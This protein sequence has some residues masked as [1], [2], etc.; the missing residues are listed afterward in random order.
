MVKTRKLK[1]LFITGATHKKH[2]RNLNHFQRVYFLSRWSD[3]SILASK[4]SDFSLSAYPGTKI[5]R[6]LFTNKMASLIY[7]IFWLLARGRRSHF[8][9][10]ITEPS[11][12]SICGFWAKIILNI[13]WVVDVWDIP[14]RNQ[15]HIV[16]MRL[17]TRTERWIL[18]IL[19]RQ[20]DLFI[21]SILPEYEL[22]DFKLPPDKMLLLKNA[23]WLDEFPKKEYPPSSDGLFK[24]LC[25]RGRYSIDS[26]LDI[27]AQAYRGICKDLYVSL[28]I[29]GKIST[30]ARSHLDLLNGCPRVYY[31]DFIEHNQLLEMI[32]D[33][34]ACIIPYKNVPDLAQIYPV[35]G[36]EYMAL[37]AAII[38]SDIG[39][40]AKMIRQRWN[41]LLFKAGDSK[42]LAC[43]IRTLYNDSELRKK[44]S[45]NAQQLMKGEYDCEEK[46]R[47][48][49]SRIKGLVNKEK[50]NLK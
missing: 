27:L 17:K 46:N 32:R 45:Q 39:G 1:I 2:M 12:Y 40:L 23:I 19:F 30:K 36:L 7:F 26:G 43:Q 24:I 13:K 11:L 10:V 37:G 42:D 14:I 22:K 29:I 49:M 47:I 20:A 25:M 35:K 8:D 5:F 4:K 28:I 44:L 9:L 31:H 38:A 48:I 18:R 41:G 21:V 3:L 6:S 16:L 33:A 15:S 50:N 34:S